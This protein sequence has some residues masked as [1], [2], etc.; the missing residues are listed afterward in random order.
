MVSEIQRESVF[1]EAVSIGIRDFDDLI[2]NSVKPE[3]VDEPVI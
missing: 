2:Q 3:P 1:L